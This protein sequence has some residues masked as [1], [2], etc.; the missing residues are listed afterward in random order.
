MPCCASTWRAPKLHFPISSR[1][2]LRSTGMPRTRTGPRIT[3]EH[4]PAESR[5]RWAISCRTAIVIEL[6]LC[7]WSFNGQRGCVFR[8]TTSTY[9]RFAGTR[10]EPYPFPSRTVR[11]PLWRGIVRT[12][13]SPLTIGED[14]FRRPEAA[15]THTGK[16]RLRRSFQP[17]FSIH[18][19]TGHRA[20][21]TPVVC[22]APRARH[23]GN[24]TPNFSNFRMLSLFQMEYRSF[25]TQ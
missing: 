14:G 4:L 1:P 7:G 11:S 5:C 8:L 16:N 17:S 15:C 12:F 19:V 22:R 6:A 21:P 18:R 25:C 2:R 23:D 3:G 13:F 24:P 20:G 9:R 10:V